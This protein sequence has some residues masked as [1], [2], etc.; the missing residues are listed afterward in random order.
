M[1]EGLLDEDAACI[2]QDLVTLCGGARRARC[3]GSCATHEF[4][5][6]DA[7]PA[8]CQKALRCRELKDVHEDCASRVQASGCESYA[9]KSCYLSCARY[10]LGGLLRRFRATV[11]VR[12]RKHGVLDEVACSM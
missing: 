11:S 3:A 8:E 9:L 2:D 6:A 7:D 4:C 5:A 1:V 12:T 10:D